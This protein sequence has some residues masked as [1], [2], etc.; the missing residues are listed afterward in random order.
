MK[1]FRNRLEVA[2]NVGIDVSGR[3]LS[4]IK[5]GLAWIVAGQGKPV[6]FYLDGIRFE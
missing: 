2:S 1:P 6:V 4:C 5:T 3:D